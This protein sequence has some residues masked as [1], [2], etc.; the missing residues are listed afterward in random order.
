MLQRETPTA[1]LIKHILGREV[2]EH[3]F[4]VVS[5]LVYWAQNHSDK[6]AELISSYLTAKINALT[7]RKR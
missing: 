5:I 7:K 6:L 1:N 3:D 2:K 4:F